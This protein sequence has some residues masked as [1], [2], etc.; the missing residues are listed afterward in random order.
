M[1]TNTNIKIHIPR[2]VL[3]PRYRPGVGVRPLRL[4]ACNNIV[5]ELDHRNTRPPSENNTA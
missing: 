1:T 5:L 2:I 3:R 4:L